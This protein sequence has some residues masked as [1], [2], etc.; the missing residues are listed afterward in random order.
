MQ[1][2]RTAVACRG[3]NGSGPPCRA[4]ICTLHEPHHTQVE[5]MHRGDN[6][7]TRAQ[8]SS[9]FNWPVT[10]PSLLVVTNLERSGVKLP[11]NFWFQWRKSRSSRLPCGIPWSSR[12]CCMRGAHAKLCSCSSRL[13]RLRKVRIKSH[14]TSRQG[15]MGVSRARAADA[16]HRPSRSD[17]LA[18]RA[19]FHVRRPC[20]HPGYFGLRARHLT[21]QPPSGIL[22]Q[23]LINPSCS[24]VRDRPENT[25]YHNR[26]RNLAMRRN[27]WKERT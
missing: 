10:V 27:P 14:L 1:S 3:G 21:M 15:S 4:Y 23:I 12:G 13:K 8:G 6:E 18:Q 9:S 16:R 20:L 25:D 19:Q 24:D 11:A 2:S 5:P 22:L 17:S 7:K 26:E